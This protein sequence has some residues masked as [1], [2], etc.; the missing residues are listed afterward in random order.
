[1][2]SAPKS[3][4]LLLVGG[5]HSHLSVIMQLAMRPVEGLKITVISRDVLTPYSGMLPG[6][7]AGHYRHEQCH[8]DLRRLCQWAGIRLIHD[9]VTA[10]D[11]NEQKISCQRYPDF[12]YDYLSVNTGSRPDLGGIAGA[13]EVGCAVK[14]VDEF[15]AYWQSF[16]DQLSSDSQLNI[17]VVGGG[18]ASVEVLLACQFRLQ[19]FCRQQ[20]WSGSENN[21]QFQI[22][23]ASKEILCSHNPRVRRYFKR[24]LETRSVRQHCGQ[25]VI[26]AGSLEQDGRQQH[27]LKLANGDCIDADAVIWALQAGSPRWPRQAGLACDEKGFIEV[28]RYLQSLSHPNVFAAGD[29]ASLTPQGVAKSGVYAVKAGTTLAHNLRRVITGK[30]LKA[31]RPQKKFLSLLATGDRQAIASRGIFNANGSWVWRWKDRIDRR[32]MAR[33]NELPAML[34]DRAQTKPA[35]D[36]ADDIAQ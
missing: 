17:A 23:T 19:Q 34:T 28:N 35:D 4:S 15:L 11:C 25:K 29:V 24:L 21:F 22:I 10:I 18:A 26:A 1:M 27:H 16:E 12:H 7:I 30:P 32:F 14:P 3:Q 9:S 36:S 31:Y 2:Q 33:F 20:G 13:T 5:G 6:F 8:I